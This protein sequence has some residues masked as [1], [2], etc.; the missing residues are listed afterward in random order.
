M[1]LQPYTKRSSNIKPLFELLPM[2]VPFSIWVEPTNKC[3]FRCIS[4]P[5]GNKSFLEKTKR[6][7]GFMDYDLYLNIIKDIE[8]LCSEY[9]E[10]LNRLHLYKDGEPMLHK[11][12]T[13]NGFECKED[14]S[15]RF[16]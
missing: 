1:T 3:N 15:N 11:K 10:K 14:K 6:P 12:N 5:T 9:S 13:L 8:V 7:S 2:A 16:C 4:C